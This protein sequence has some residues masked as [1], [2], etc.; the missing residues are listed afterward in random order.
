[1]EKKKKGDDCDLEIAPPRTF[2]NSLVIIKFSTART[3]VEQ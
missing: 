2:W 3:S 1:M